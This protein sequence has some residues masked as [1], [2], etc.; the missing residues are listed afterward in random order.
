MSGLDVLA[1]VLRNQMDRASRCSAQF[2]ENP[3]IGGLHIPNHWV[4]FVCRPVSIDSALGA[5]S[6]LDI[7][8]PWLC[9][10]ARSW[11][12]S[13]PKFRP[14]SEQSPCLLIRNPRFL[15]CLHATFHGPHACFARA[16]QC[17]QVIASLSGTDI[18]PLAA[19]WCLQFGS[20][21][22]KVSNTTGSSTLGVQHGRHKTCQRARYCPPPVLSTIQALPP[23]GYY[24]PGLVL[25]PR[26]HRRWS[27][28]RP[29]GPQD[30]QLVAVGRLLPPL[31]LVD[32]P[33][34]ARS[35]SSASKADSI[36]CL[37]VFEGFSGAGTV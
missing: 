35:T 2:C 11:Q 27:S 36:R 13:W 24:P 17:L 9:A 18:T 30:R 32:S 5:D 19:H 3:A 21:S 20:H 6:A 33:Q 31:P 16:H 34:P 7:G 37:H 4:P 12:T 25:H 8:C 1:T 29:G 10:G 14:R 15:V 22:I 26:R 28:H 23:Q